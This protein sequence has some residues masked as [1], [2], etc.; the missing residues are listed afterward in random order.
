[1]PYTERILLDSVEDIESQDCV[2][3]LVKVQFR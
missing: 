3:C 2:Y 1:M